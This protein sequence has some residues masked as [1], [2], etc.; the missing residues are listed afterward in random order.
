MTEET[1][2]RLITALSDLGN[3]VD[4]LNTRMNKLDDFK[5]EVSHLKTVIGDLQ[6]SIDDRL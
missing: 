2:E 4:I 1:A 6:L 3:S 5:T